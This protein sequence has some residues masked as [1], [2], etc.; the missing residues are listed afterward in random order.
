MNRVVSDLYEQLE[1]LGRGS[2]AVVYKV[3]HVDQE[4]IFALKMSPL[5]LLDDGGQATRFE[6]ASRLLTPIRHR[7]LVQV[8]G[9]GRDEALKLSYLVMEYIRGKTLRQY[10]QEKGPLRLPEV[11]ELTR[12]VAGALAYAHALTPPVIHHNIKPTNIMIEDMTGRV[13]VLDFGIAQE[14]DAADQEPMK[15]GLIVDDWK[16]ASPERLHREP[17]TASADVYSLGMVMYEMYTGAQ[18]YANLDENGVRRRVLHEPREH[19]PYFARPTPPAFVAVITKAIAKA[20]EKRYRRM[21]DLLNDLE[22]CWWALDETRTIALQIPKLAK[23][24]TAPAPEEDDVAAIEAQLRTLTEERQKRAAALL[25]TQAKKTR[26]QAERVDAK[27]WATAVFDQGV[28]QHERGEGYWREGQYPAAQEAYQAAHLLLTQAIEEATTI[29]AA[30]EAEQSREQANGAKAEAE[31]QVANEW[32]TSLYTEALTIYL[33]A[34]ELWLSRAFAQAKPCFDEARRLFESART[35]ASE[36]ALRQAVAEARRQARSAKEAAVHDGAD[37]FAGVM[38]R[39]AVEYEQQA[40]AALERGALMQARECYRVAR[41][42]YEAAQRQSR[43]EQQRQLSAEAAAR[44]AL[45]APASSEQ[46]AAGIEL[47]HQVEHQEEQPACREAAS[48]HEGTQ[49]RVEGALG[50]AKETEQP[51]VL[52]DMP[53]ASQSAQQET[54]HARAHAQQ[55]LENAASA[56]GMK[57]EQVRNAIALGDHLFQQGKYKEAKGPYEAAILLLEALAETTD[58]SE[59]EQEIDTATT[60]AVVREDPA[61]MLSPRPVR[62]TLFGAVVFGKYRFIGLACLLIVAGIYL[63]RWPFSNGDSFEEET[64]HTARELPPS[65][66]GP[67]QDTMPRVTKVSPTE[68]QL[69]LREG[70]SQEFRIVVEGAESETLHYLWQVNGQ[71]RATEER[72]TYTPGFDEGEDGP[73]DVSVIVSDGIRQLADHHWTVR[74]DNMNRPPTIVRASPR[75]NTTLVLAAGEEQPFVVDAL[76]PD[77]EDRLTYIWRL[78]GQEV[79]RGKT[80]RF[81]ASSG[82]RTHKISVA[83]A[84]QSGITTTVEWRATV[85]APTPPR[86]V[87]GRATRR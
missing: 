73:K 78:D 36:E 23:P 50:S 83:V 10:L 56:L 63:L 30:C 14:P 51:A 29:M 17:L 61:P 1:E 59:C 71:P 37:S 11:L 2:Q 82:A 58:E 31:Q 18:F 60:H 86:Q 40:T 48:R 38:L 24:P 5:R 53:Q 65:P 85:Q 79:S 27:R 9:S 46:E 8:F 6:Q 54:Q 39:E 33:R 15:T 77:T 35:L 28:T 7:N 4:T 66:P 3:R 12:Q 21:A 13:V 74:V 44:Q 26:E 19:E 69:T 62:A 52:V 34:E 76:D 72:W 22:A 84:D 16:Y 49:P 20:R 41:Q 43:V 67:P 70:E 68:G 25:Q 45:A 64:S 57:S 42:H 80:W 47:P 75:A 87:N 81:Q 55:L 32:A